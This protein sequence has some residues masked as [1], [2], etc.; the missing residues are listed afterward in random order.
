MSLVLL[1]Q[2]E[3]A[4][5]RAERAA[6][7]LV[8]SAAIYRAIGNLLYVPWCLE[9]LAGLAAAQ[10]AWK[11]AAR[12]CGA[13]DALRARLGAPIPPC[14]PAG[15]AH[16]VASIHAALGETGFAAAHAE[17][18]GLPAEAALE[19]ASMSMLGDAAL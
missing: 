18:E 9:G 19:E 13:R 1:A 3:L 5:D 11:R 4:E 8:E 16:M 6:G 15:Y 2:T 14:Y 7:L 12:F 17:G 10:G